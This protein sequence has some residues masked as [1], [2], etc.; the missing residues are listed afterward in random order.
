MNDAVD[1]G[2]DAET[3]GLA[4]VVE[5]E[6]GEVDAGFDGEHDAGDECAAVLGFDVVD[7]D[8]VPVDD[9][10]QA[11]AGAVE[12][13]LGVTG[14][15]D[16]GADGV[17]DFIAGERCAGFKGLADEGDAGVA[18]LGDDV[19]DAAGDRRRFSAAVGHP[20]DIGEAVVGIGGFF[21]PEID[22][23]EVAGTDWA[24]LLCA[25]CVV[26]DGGV[27]VDGD[28]GIVAPGQAGGAEAFD[29]ELLDVVLGDLLLLGQ[30]V[31]HEGEGRVFGGE[32]VSGGAAVAFHLLGGEHGL[33]DLNEVGAA[34]DGCVGG[35]AHHFE[36]AG[37][38]FADVGDGAIGAVFHGDAAGRVLGQDG[39]E[40]F[41]HLLPADV[42]VQRAGQFGVGL[43]EGGLFDGVDEPLRLAFGWDPEKPTPCSGEVELGDGGGDWVLAAKVVEEPAGQ[44]LLAQVV[45]DCL[46]LHVCRP[47]LASL[48]ALCCDVR[49]LVS[50]R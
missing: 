17:V 2:A 21:G 32:H 29:D 46:Q 47:S 5:V 36:G 28:D 33:Y 1:F 50:K 45:A 48:G 26:G 42:E 18:C 43:T 19:K 37:V 38:D 12:D 6:V 25:G 8:T 22:E 15:F 9:R 44:V 16:D 34:D 31:G 13:A 4:A 20:G 39:V 23:H 27:A 11:V 24:V 41:L 14:V 40:F 7:V 35:G 10:S 30:G 49:Y 3:F